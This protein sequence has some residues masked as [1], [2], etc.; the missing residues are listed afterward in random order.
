MSQITANKRKSARHLV[1]RTGRIVCSD[2]TFS[3]ECAILNLSDHGASILVPTGAVVPES[4]TL[5]MDH[6]NV[7][8]ACKL[9]WREGV[10]I[11]VSFA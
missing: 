8:L 11:G 2:E 10:R 9:A 5:R 7:I 1:F 3:L 6:G 4:F